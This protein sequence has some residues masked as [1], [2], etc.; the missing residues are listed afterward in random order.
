MMDERKTGVSRRRFIKQAAAAGVGVLV[1][2]YVRPTLKTVHIQPAF[3]AGTPT[4][5]PTK[6]NPI[7]IEYWLFKPGVRHNPIM[8]DEEEQSKFMGYFIPKGNQQFMVDGQL[9]EFKADADHPNGARFSAGKHNGIDIGY[10]VDKECRVHE[11]G[12]GALIYPTQAGRVHELKSGEDGLLR[13]GHTNASHYDLYGH[14]APDEGI[15]MGH[16]IVTGS[17]I[18][19]MGSALD[20]SH[21]HYGETNENGQW[22][23]PMQFM[24]KGTC[25]DP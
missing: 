11:I 9:T 17:P 24:T 18:G 25:V 3:A 4:P 7:T 10:W 19:C 6:S 1:G 15:E 16:D 5:T 23:D 14:I 2:T 8:L 22:V 12:A 20:W 13:I 21:L